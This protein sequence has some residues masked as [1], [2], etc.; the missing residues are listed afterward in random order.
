MLTTWI[1]FDRDESPAPRLPGLHLPASLL[2]YFSH[3]PACAACAGF[4]Q[5]LASQPGALQAADAALVVVSPAPLEVPPGVAFLADPD[6]L[7]ERRFR[8]ILEFDTG[9]QRLLF[10]LDRYNA[11]YKAWTGPEPDPPALPAETLAALE[12]LAI[13]CPE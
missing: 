1:G 7:L 8:Q 3:G 6:G 9:S 2:V 13:R 11:P 12:R 5:A 4:V 10:V